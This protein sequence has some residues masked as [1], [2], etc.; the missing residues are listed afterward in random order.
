M[1]DYLIGQRLKKLRKGREKHKSRCDLDVNYASEQVEK[2]KLEIDMLSTKFQ[3]MLRKR[4]GKHNFFPSPS[5]PY[6]FLLEDLISAL[7]SYSSD[8]KNTVR[9]IENAQFEKDCAEH[10]QRKWDEQAR[11][12]TQIE[13]SLSR[14]LESMKADQIIRKCLA[15]HVLDKKLLGFRGPIYAP[16]FEQDNLKT[17]YAPN[18]NEH[19]LE[20]IQVGKLDYSR[21]ELHEAAIH[22]TQPIWS[23]LTVSPDMEIDRPAF[24]AW[25]RMMRGFK[26]HLLRP[27]PWVLSD[28]PDMDWD[29]KFMSEYILRTFPAL[30]PLLASYHWSSPENPA[31]EMYWKHIGKPL[32]EWSSLFVGGMRKMVEAK[33]TDLIAS[34]VAAE[35]TIKKADSV[36]QHCDEQ[37]ELAKSEVEKTQKLQARL[38]GILKSNNE[39]TEKILTAMRTRSSVSADDIIAAVKGARD[40]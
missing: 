16:G 35:E 12:A 2:L 33:F 10:A 26:G 20:R 3:G 24:Y 38:E 36:K 1:Q 21:G 4:A 8:A 23:T 31:Q 11:L 27:Y 19:P 29:M 34:L 9:R 17:G 13:P 14:V 6:E 28:A 40:G 5:T 25:E 18:L 7:H 15:N 22:F 30:K 32:T 39:T 37:V